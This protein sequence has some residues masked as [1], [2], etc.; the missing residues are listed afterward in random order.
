LEAY[1]GLFIAFFTSLD[2]LLLRHGHPLKAWLPAVWIRIFICLA[3]IAAP[4]FPP[5]E[6][7]GDVGFWYATYSVVGIGL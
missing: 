6:G 2:L 5:A 1:P 3:L 7:R 4:F